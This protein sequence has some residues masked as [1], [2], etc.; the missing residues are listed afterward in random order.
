MSQVLVV[1][2]DPDIRRLLEIRVGRMGHTVVGVTSA[3]DA[4]E[5]IRNNGEPDVMVLDIVMHGTSGIELL[6]KLR[7]RPGLAELPVIL[8]TARD[9]DDDVK[10]ARELHAD[11]MQKPIELASLTR[12]LNR[13]LA[14]T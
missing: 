2:D 4:W 11:L 13:A 7:D 9:L 6:R 12:A 10:V 8:L 5:A 14:P 1:E 3:Q